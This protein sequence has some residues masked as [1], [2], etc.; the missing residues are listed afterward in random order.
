MSAVNNEVLIDISTQNENRNPPK[1]P[2]A[3][4]NPF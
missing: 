2:F 4:K 3:Q 1:A